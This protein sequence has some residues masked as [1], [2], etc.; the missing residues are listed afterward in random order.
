[1]SYEG[2]DFFVQTF[3][4]LSLLGTYYLFIYL[5]V[6]LIKVLY[7]FLLILFFFMFIMHV[8]PVSIYADGVGINEFN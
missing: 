8:I 4:F 3:V 6:L 5:F 7:L 2:R 1:M